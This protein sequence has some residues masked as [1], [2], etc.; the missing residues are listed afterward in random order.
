MDTIMSTGLIWVI[1]AAAILP[2]ACMV[3]IILIHND[4]TKI[5]RQLERIT[6]LLEGRIDVDKD[7]V[8]D[9]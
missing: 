5:R 8:D 6:E 2:L 7:T 3:A 9:I 4:V 1:L